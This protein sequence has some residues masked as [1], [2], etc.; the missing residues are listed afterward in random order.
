MGTRTIA[1]R[2]NSKNREDKEILDWLDSVV[3]ENEIYE[4]LTEAVKWALLSFAR[5]EV[6]N[7]WK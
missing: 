1:F 5:G 7:V 3:Y 6:S 4:S 2:L